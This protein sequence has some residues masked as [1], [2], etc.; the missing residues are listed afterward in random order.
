LKF[1]F[2]QHKHI[3]IFLILINCFTA[4]KNPEPVSA[5]SAGK[6]NSVKYAKRFAIREDKNFTRVYVFGDRR[7][8][9]TTSTF[10][11]Y[12]GS[13]SLDFLPAKGIRI[14]SPCEK[15]AAL[16]SIYATMF[17]ELGAVD[18]LAAI[19]NID[20]VNNPLIIRKYREGKLK[21][22]AKGPQIDLEQTIV[23][24]PDIVF[25]FGMGNGDK[26][27]DTKLEQTG[28]PVAVSIDH[29]EESPLARAE[30][31]KFFALFVNKRK[32]AD[33][34]FDQ[35]EKR[36]G[37]LKA[38]AAQTTSRPTVFNEIKY[39]DSW[40][41]PGG[42]SFVAQLLNDAAADYLWKDDA[43]A[44]SLPLSFEQVFAKAKEADFW[45]NLST[46]KTKKELLG[47]ESR[48]AEFKAYKTGNLFNNTKITNS[49]GYSNYWETG[50]I[51]PDRILSDLVQ[52]FHPELKAQ[53]RQDFYY[54]EQIR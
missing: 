28:I 33:S 9:D 19:D 2:M 34:I 42:K 4:C 5:P 15:I 23:L 6:E 7:N 31:I 47:F 43:N 38:I 29:L 12:S 52:I 8:Y 13:E 25:T 45:I 39:S 49:K 10:V 51:Y 18:K 54:Y 14:K 21:E 50:M 17:C 46:L 3:C 40:Y 48:Y 41:M 16:S 1:N 36:Y 24:N 11:I 20:Y 30:W 37:E 27:K 44:G 53:V 26:D 35:V 22:L 32:E